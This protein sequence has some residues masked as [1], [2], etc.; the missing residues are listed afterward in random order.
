MQNAVDVFFTLRRQVAALMLMRDVDKVIASFLSKCNFSV[1]VS[2]HSFLLSVASVCVYATS[3]SHRFCCKMA[4]FYL[5]HHHEVGSA[6][7]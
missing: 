2:V 1:R 3:K 7:C 6:G 4:S 5:Q